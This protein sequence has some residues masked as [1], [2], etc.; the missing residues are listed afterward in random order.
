MHGLD[1]IR[2]SPEWMTAFTSLVYFRVRYL[3]QQKKNMCYERDQS[4]AGEKYDGRTERIIMS[5]DRI[6]M[7]QL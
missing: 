1:A 6:K 4:Q 2:V 5:A 7:Y 3:S